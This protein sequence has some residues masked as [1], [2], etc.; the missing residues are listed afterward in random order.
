MA[1]P[2]IQLLE[3]DCYYGIY[4]SGE[5]LDQGD[6][7]DASSFLQ[8]LAK[9]GLIDFD[10]EIYTEIADEAIEQGGGHAPMTWDVVEMIREESEA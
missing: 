10:S 5:L 9:R 6:E 2:K 3:V 4:L 1:K 8:Q 7:F